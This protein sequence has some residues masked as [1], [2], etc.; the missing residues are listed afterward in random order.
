VEEYLKLYALQDEFLN[1][2]ARIEGAWYLTGGTC[3]HRFYFNKRYSDDLDI[4]YADSALYRDFIREIVEYSAFVTP[5]ELEVL[6]DSRDFVR[7]RIRNFL[8]IDIVN[9][10]TWR[11]GRPKI[12]N[13]GLKIDN[14]TNIAANKITAVL[15]RDEPK[16]V[17][18]LLCIADS[19]VVDWGEVFMAAKKKEIFDKEDFV[20]RIK[21]FPL[22][23]MDSIKTSDVDYRERL[24]NNIDKFLS[25]LINGCNDFQFE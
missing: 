13:N 4:F 5:L 3:L 16:D 10:R 6:V 11:Y 22:V 24:K 9:D 7:L 20:G 19:G 25:G 23:L 18:D 1:G 15:G 14:I 21:T 2:M 8:K 12:I 17:F